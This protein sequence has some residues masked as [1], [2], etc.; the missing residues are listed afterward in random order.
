MAR[1]SLGIYMIV[2]MIRCISHVH[3]W[4]LSGIPVMPTV[5]EMKG[6]MG[7]EA[8]KSVFSHDGEIVEP[9]YHKLLL[10]DYNIGVELTS[11]IRLVCIVILILKVLHLIYYLILGFFGALRNGLFYGEKSE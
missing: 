3:A 4:Q 8:Y 11:T 10:K 1:G 5:G 2:L 7:M 6:H 9:G